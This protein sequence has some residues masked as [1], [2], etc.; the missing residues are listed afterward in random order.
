LFSYVLEEVVSLLS[1]FNDS[2]G[3]FMATSIGNFGSRPKTKKYGISSNVKGT[4]VLWAKTTAGMFL[5][6]FV[7]ET[8]EII[9]ANIF[10][11][12]ALKLSVN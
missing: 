8:P 6:Q 2:V 10:A 7:N 1:A 9:T 4:L 11:R 5:S 3:R 12:V